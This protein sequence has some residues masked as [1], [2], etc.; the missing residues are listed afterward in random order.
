MAKPNAC[1]HL[2]TCAC[3][4][5]L[6]AGLT[7]KQ[8]TLL[9]ATTGDI[10]AFL[11]R[12]PLVAGAPLCGGPSLLLPSGH[13]RS[14]CGYS[15]ESTEAT[16]GRSTAWRVYACL[17][18]HGCCH[19]V[20][21]SW[22][23]CFAGAGWLCGRQPQPL[24]RTGWCG[25]R[26]ATHMNACPRCRVCHLL[27]VSFATVTG[28]NTRAGL[29]GTHLQAHAPSSPAHAAAAMALKSSL[30]PSTVVVTSRRWLA[31][32]KSACTSGRASRFV[33]RLA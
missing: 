8:G 20:V 32:L 21:W 24:M 26:A 19:V 18:C 25:Q 22:D 15:L 2:H 6:L 9:G 5:R 17:H 16:P 23:T 12:R 33:R 11:A 7:D 27:S 31:L 29:I 1:V 3:V 14:C 4:D 10:L 13:Q 28:T 30:L